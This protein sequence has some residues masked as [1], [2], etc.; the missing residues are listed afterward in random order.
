MSDWLGT[1]KQKITENKF[2]KISH[3]VVM[4]GAEKKFYNKKKIQ[5]IKKNLTPAH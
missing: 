1:K 4:K 5:N 2:A 3:S